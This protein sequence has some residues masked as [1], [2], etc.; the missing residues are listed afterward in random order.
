MNFKNAAGRRDVGQTCKVRLPPAAP[1]PLM[2]MG[3]ATPDAALS[4]PAHARWRLLPACQLLRL[5]RP[6]P[7]PK[8]TTARPSVCRCQANPTTTPASKRQIGSARAAR[9]RFSALAARRRAAAQSLC[10]RTRDG[11]PPSN[12]CAWR[13]GVVALPPKPL[14]M[15]CAH[16]LVV[17]PRGRAATYLRPPLGGRRPFRGRRHPQPL[18]N[19]RRAAPRPRR[20]GRPALA[21]ALA[22]ALWR[23][24]RRSLGVARRRCR[25]SCR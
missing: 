24:R 2:R 5:L 17:P 15:R 9:A 6:G 13:S 20:A 10:R 14:P 11:A 7:A 8:L 22:L 21:A 12:S 19:H 1:A 18:L 3:G 25:W 4:T 16:G 23:R